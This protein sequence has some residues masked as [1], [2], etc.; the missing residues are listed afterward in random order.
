MSE[1][2]VKK[3][4]QWGFARLGYT[5]NKLETVQHLSVQEPR[6]GEFYKKCSPF[7]LT[8]FER[9]YALYKSLEYIAK[10]SIEGDIVE[11]GVWKGGSSMLIAS[12]LK[13]RG[14]TNRQLYL[15][16]T[17]EGMPAPTEKDVNFKGEGAAVEMEEFA[18]EGK[19]L[20][21]AG[22]EE[23]KSN[24]LK[25]GFAEERMHF[26]KGMVEDT[27]PKTIPEKI[28][29]LRLDTDWH[30]ST[31]HELEHLF[32]RLSKHGVLIIDD[33]GHWQGA[34]EAVDEYFEKNGVKMLLNRIDL[35]GR[36]GIKLED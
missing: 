22:I 34:R 19:N 16:D 18:E 14:E 11:C 7:T 12:D 25:T 9:M 10:H 3:I 36:I 35:P 26:V 30:A 27:I 4:L 17:Y 8:S 21:E 28:S 31:L 32:P 24:L 13:D 15:Y 1:S 23:V 6:F 20:F 2:K 33:Y 29:L 5:V